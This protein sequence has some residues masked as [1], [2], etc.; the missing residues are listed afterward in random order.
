MQSLLRRT[1][2]LAY[3]LMFV[4]LAMGLMAQS[5]SAGIV[6]TDTVLAEQ[7]QLERAAVLGLLDRDDV[8]DKLIEY[9]VSPEEAKERVAS[10][11]DQEALELAQRIDDMPA[12]ASGA[13][14][15]LL[16]LI[17]LILLLR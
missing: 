3:P 4:F 9:G 13:V 6:G 10:L 5:A 2:F 17:L 15:L 16:V 11:T 7:A 8:R 12:G 14:V 1:R